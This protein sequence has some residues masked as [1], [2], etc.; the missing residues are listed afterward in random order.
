MTGQL[1]LT[2]EQYAKLVSKGSAVRAWQATPA[3]GAARSMTMNKTEAAYEQMLAF[4]KHAGEI[5]WYGFESMTFKLA[6]RTRYTPDFP[7]ML[8]DGSIEIHEV[9]GGYVRDDGW[10]KLKIAA[11]L[12]PFRFLKCQLSKGAWTVTPVPGWV[13]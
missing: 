9:K 6:D 1:R 10:A 12:F 3:K 13:K 11:S 8:A 2:P 5:V 4:R 7:V